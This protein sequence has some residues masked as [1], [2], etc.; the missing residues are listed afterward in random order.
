M[1]LTWMYILPQT[2][3]NFFI[4]VDATGQRFSSHWFA[5]PLKDAVASFQQHHLTTRL[6]N[7]YRD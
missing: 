6:W 7:V 5:V 2:C 1:G 4:H 3:Q